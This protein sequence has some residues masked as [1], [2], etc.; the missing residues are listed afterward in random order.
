MN[1]EAVSRHYDPAQTLTPI[2]IEAGLFATLQKEGR[3]AEH[4]SVNSRAAEKSLLEH[5]VSIATI[6][7]SPPAYQPRAEATSSVVTNVVNPSKRATIFGR[8]ASDLDARFSKSDLK[9]K[10]EKAAGDFLDAM[11]PDSQTDAATAVGCFDISM[12]E[13]FAVIDNFKASTLAPGIKNEISASLKKMAAKKFLHSGSSVNSATVEKAKAILELA[14]QGTVGQPDS[15]ATSTS[16]AVA[17]QVLKIFQEQLFYNL[18]IQTKKITNDLLAA[19]EPKSKTTIAAASKVFEEKMKAISEQREHLKNHDLYKDF[20][21]NIETSSNEEA[22]VIYHADVKK[23]NM[24]DWK[25]KS[26]K[27]AEENGAPVAENYPKDIL[28]PQVILSK[29]LAWMKGNDFSNKIK[30][31]IKEVFPQRYE[32]IIRTEEDKITLSRSTA[33]QTYA[34]KIVEAHAETIEATDTLLGNFINIC[35]ESCKEYGEEYI[36]KTIQGNRAYY[37][38][39]LMTNEN[40]IVTSKNPT[41]LKIGVEKYLEKHNTNLS[42]AVCGMILDHLELVQKQDLYYQDLYYQ[43][44]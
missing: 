7:H 11:A 36:A 20:A 4:I 24:A 3:V 21:K 13:I 14:D 32:R 16:R 25:A 44:G 5:C 2:Y 18:K 37:T 19:A 23:D 10:A 38:Q 29:Q 6:N 22:G 39:I 41:R 1:N 40:T 26:K 27:L 34:S 17:N 12:R 8:I 30:A 28:T 35:K 42:L 15:T 33:I 9:S 43:E 31:S